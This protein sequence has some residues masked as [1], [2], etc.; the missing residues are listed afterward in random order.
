MHI[1]SSMDVNNKRRRIFACILF[2]LYFVILFYFLFFSE[3]M[4]RTYSERAYHY[5]LVPFKEINRFL[6][7]RRALGMKAVMLNIVGNIAAFVPLGIL[8]PV[9]SMQCEKLWRT[10]LYSFELSFLVEVLQL[11]FRVGSFDVDDLILNTLGGLLGF[12]L[13]FIGRH[14]IRGGGRG[15]KTT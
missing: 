6:T 15:E 2:I 7:Y 11:V 14:I 3:K 10:V 5:N 9:F 4:G 13:H 8:L 12:L 1:I